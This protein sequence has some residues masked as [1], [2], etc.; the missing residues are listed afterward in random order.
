MDLLERTPIILYISIINNLS[1]YNPI[2]SE[3]F[4]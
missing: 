3:S 4:Q 1:D 2:F